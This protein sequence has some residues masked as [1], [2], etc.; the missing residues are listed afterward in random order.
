[1]EPVSNNR[2]GTGSVKNN[3]AGELSEA[4]ATAWQMQ[5]LS[6][7]KTLASLE[8]NIEASRNAIAALAERVR[9]LE[10]TVGRQ[11]PAVYT[12]FA[13]LTAGLAQAGKGLDLPAETIRAIQPASAWSRSRFE[14]FQNA[15]ERARKAAAAIGE[16]PPLP[17]GI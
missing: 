15:L 7:S 10:E 9:R 2:N 4:L 13:G 11:G 5:R 1:M 6:M 8:Q 12:Q 14:E 3:I 16:A 17:D